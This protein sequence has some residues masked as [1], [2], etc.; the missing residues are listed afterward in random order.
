MS[1]ATTWSI[2]T[3]SSI[4]LKTWRRKHR[5]NCATSAAFPKSGRDA[6][7]TCGLEALRS[8]ATRPGHMIEK[9]REI[10]KFTGIM[11]GVFVGLAVLGLINK[12]RSK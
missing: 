6:S 8:S 7:T 3:I 1:C 11:A 5:F 10:W 4:R 12:P 2:S 9:Q